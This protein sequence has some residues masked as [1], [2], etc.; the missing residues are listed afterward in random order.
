MPE[1]D[2]AEMQKFIDGLERFTK[3][4]VRGLFRKEHEAARDEMHQLVRSGLPGSRKVAGWQ[5][6]YVGS[7][8]GY[9]AIRPEIGE[10]EGYAKGYI[11]NAIENGHLV[12]PRASS[13]SHG[14]HRYTGQFRVKG[15]GFYAKA[16]SVMK[17]V[18]QNH[19]KSL[20]GEIKGGLE[21][22]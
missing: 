9:A 5:E 16:R 7:G 13:K 1:I 3:K 18:A 4:E 10:H 19:A 12:R 22:L 17:Q 8:G 15:L 21:S 2:L 11:T 14:Y 6:K 20:E